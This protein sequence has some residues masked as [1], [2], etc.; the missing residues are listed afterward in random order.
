MSTPLMPRLLGD[1]ADWV[2]LDRP[3]P[4]GNL[5][6]VEDSLTDR[7]YHLRAELPGLN[8]TENIYVSVDNGIL[9]I[10]AEREERQ[11]QQGRSE[12]RYGVME[13][14][15]RLPG[16]ADPDGITATYD[17]G[18]LDVTVPLKDKES[19]GRRIPVEPAT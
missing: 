7:E 13:R 5:I 19:A 18:I 15:V 9:H 11:E 1:L 14:A 8:P 12:F 3:Q 16:S 4:A 2:V 17:K 10:H 6:R